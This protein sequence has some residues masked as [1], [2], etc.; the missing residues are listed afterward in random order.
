MN[1]TQSFEI[2]NS[3]IFKKTLYSLIV[4]ATPK[5][6][7]EYAWSSV[8]ILLKDLRTNYHFLKYVTI[9]QLQ[10]LSFTK[11]DITI[12]TSLNDVDS[13][14]IGKALQDLIDLLKKRLGNK[15]GYFFLQ[16]FKQVLGETYHQ[17]I[18]E[19]GVDLRI[20]ELQNKIYGV[21]KTDY[22]IKDTQD[23]NIAY[24]RKT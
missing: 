15:A 12:S 23:S 7:D 11:D 1:Q 14:E 4:V 22:A 13:K 10:N 2:N 17:V 20:I 18:K 3:D 5:T 24:I 16:E 8:K 19:M 6:S 9:G 21:G